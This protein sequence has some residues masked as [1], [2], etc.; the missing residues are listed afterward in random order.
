MILQGNALEAF[1][2]FYHDDV[3]VQENDN[4]EFVGKAVNRKREEAFF[5]AITELEVPNH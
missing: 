4:P 3:V 1:E 2:E 5:E